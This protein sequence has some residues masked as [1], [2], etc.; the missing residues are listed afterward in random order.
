MADVLCDR[1]LYLG[2]RTILGEPE[3]VFCQLRE[4]GRLAFTPEFWENGE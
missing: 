3:D 4:E 2:D 1:L